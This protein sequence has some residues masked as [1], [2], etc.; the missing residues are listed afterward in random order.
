MRQMTSTAEKATRLAMERVLMAAIREQIVSAVRTPNGYRLEGVGILVSASRFYSMDRF[1]LR[2]WPVCGH[3]GRELTEV[4]ELLGRLNAGLEPSAQERLLF[5]LSNSRDNMEDSLEA[6]EQLG[7]G[8]TGEGTLA[9]WEGRVWEGHPLHPG[10]RLRKG[11]T[12]QEQRRFGP[13]WQV[14]FPLRLLE[15]PREDLVVR[16]P[17]WPELSRLYPGIE[18]FREDSDRVALPVHPWAAERDLP[19]RLA[20]G[21]ASGRFRWL[22]DDNVRA[23]PC[24]SFRSVVL[25][26]AN[27]PVGAHLKLPVAVQTTGATRTV[28]IS[29]AHNGPLMS[30]F[31]KSLWSLEQPEVRT[32]LRGLS[33]MFE[34]ASFHLRDN[35][36]DQARFLA[37][38][39]RKGAAVT[40]KGWLLPAAALLEP[41]DNPLFVRAAHHHGLVPLEL[42][43]A[44][45]EVLVPPQIF[46]CGELGVALETHPQNVV[47]EFLGEPGAP[48][49]LQF[50]YRDLG[51]IRMHPARLGQGLAKFGLE[52]KLDPP[53]FWPGSATST[54][55][56]RDLSSKFVYSLLQNHLGELIRATVRQTGESEGAYWD[57]L[58]EILERH[59]GDFGPDLGDRVFHP[60]WDFKTLW[61]MRIDSAVTEYTF[62]PVRNPLVSKEVAR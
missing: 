13:E 62:A 20:D 57:V 42:W 51:G 59:R 21:F 37:G 52:K 14:E 16:G 19:T 18:G 32:K 35:S 61:K 1:D 56:L 23:R 17:L 60:E 15:V 3:T 5:E 33:V 4:P 50:H 11:V 22:A 8:A 10:N 40:A 58:R 53:E 45:C 6:L 38:I 47:V 54:D 49:R 2:G 9:D 29:A 34:E 12:L 46:L 44:Y 31:L 43:R 26:D 39:L 24:M 28:S 27:G 55:S 41:R 48:P 25:H 30:R 7:E 36:S